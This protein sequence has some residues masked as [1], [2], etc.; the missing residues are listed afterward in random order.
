MQ[1][2][3]SSRSI[4]W[5]QDQYRDGRLE[6][7][8]PFQRKPVW[9]EKQRC[10]LIESIL[11]DIPIPEVYVQVLQ[12]DDGTEEFGLVDGQQRLR[13]ILQFIGLEREQDR[14]GAED[15]NNFQLDV[16]PVTSKHKGRSFSDVQGEERKAFYR[17]EVCVRFL[18]TESTRDIEDVFKRLNKFTMSLKPQELRNATYHGAFAKLAEDLA[19]DEYWA[20]NRIVT[21]AAIRRMADIEMVSD[22]LIGLLHGP[23]GGS[24]KIIDQYYEQYETFDEEFPE[25]NRVTTKFRKARACIERLFP[26]ISETRWGN[27]AD[28][29]SLFV[30]LGNLLENQSL[31][32]TKERGLRDELSRFA[33]DVDKSL[34]NPTAKAAAAAKAYARAVEKGSNERA[35]RLDRDDAVTGIVKAFL[36]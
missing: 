7:K 16:L 27:K 24:Q 19:D 5:F 20:V 32:K 6:L 13:T 31:P 30:A 29:Y 9:L 4:A 3:S 11:L 18:Y 28:F 14:H 10:A 25:Q 23:Q 26:T 34:E 15:N 35:R 8:P 2:K 33:A 21:P 36:K 17:Y 22:L 1:H 12:S